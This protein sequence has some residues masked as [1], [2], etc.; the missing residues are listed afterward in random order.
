MNEELRAR[1]AKIK[2]ILTDVDG[3]LT[4]GKLNFFV[5]PDGRVDEFK[6]FNALDGIAARMCR[7]CSIT[8]GIITGRR[9]PATI[10]R[11][12]ALGF[13]YVYQGFLTKTG[14]LEDI[15]KRENL[16]PE[17][18]AFIGDDLT[19][20]PLLLKVGLAVTVPN[21]VDAVK[22]AAHY[23]TTR[24]G[25]DGA[26]REMTDLILEAQG[27]LEPLTQQMLTS[28]WGEAKS[29][30]GLQIITSQEGIS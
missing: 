8:L 15:L 21:A 24:R 25:G 20:L 28:T 1:A 2:A 4:D 7:H 3:I 10:H 26:Y 30:N 16:R 22:K 23:I 29:P 9:H 12:R 5:L 6:S 27:K 17:E 19:D 11:A 18:V 13:S 14:P